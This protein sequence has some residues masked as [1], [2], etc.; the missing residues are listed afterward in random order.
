MAQKFYSASG[1]QGEHKKPRTNALC[2]SAYPSAGSLNPTTELRFLE[3][4]LY[5]DRTSGESTDHLNHYRLKTPLKTVSFLFF[6]LK[7]GIL[8]FREKRPQKRVFGEIF[9][10]HE[11]VRFG[12]VAFFG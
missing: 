8:E 6:N 12:T 3:L 2:E 9:E 10:D 11:N 7:L 5:S 4:N 1:Y